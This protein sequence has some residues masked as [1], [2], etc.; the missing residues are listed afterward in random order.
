MKLET[1]R[2]RIQEIKNSIAEGG[3]IL[4]SRKTSMGRKMSSDELASVQRSIDNS[5][6]KLN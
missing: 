5:K 6:A 2:S 3:M 1:D 4:K